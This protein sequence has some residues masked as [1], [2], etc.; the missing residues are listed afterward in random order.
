MFF[1]KKRS[2]RYHLIVSNSQSDLENL[3]N[4]KLSAGWVL[5]GG[6]SISHGQSMHSNGTKYPNEVLFSQAMVRGAV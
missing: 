5:V 4:A 3:V 2:I 1:R 6:V